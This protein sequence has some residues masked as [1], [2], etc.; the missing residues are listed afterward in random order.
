MLNR[1]KHI[2]NRVNNYAKQ[3]LNTL[4]R[5][6][7]YQEKTVHAS[8]ILPGK[9]VDMMDKM[10]HIIHYDSTVTLLIFFFNTF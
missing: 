6:P 8:R 9:Y 7:D 3:T 5:K 1:H 10:V 2:V 4:N